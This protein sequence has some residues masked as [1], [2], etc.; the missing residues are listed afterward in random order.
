MEWWI[1]TR[2]IKF[3]ESFF[4]VFVALLVRWMFLR[5]IRVC[6]SFIFIKVLILIIN[7]FYFYS[8]LIWVFIFVFSSTLTY[9]NLCFYHVFFKKVEYVLTF[10]IVTNNL[11]PKLSFSE[12]FIFFLLH[13][14]KIAVS[15][16][17]ILLS[18]KI[19]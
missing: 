5:R 10:E 16:I 9:F 2:I 18:I 13:F 6:N 11:F 17:S 15:T 12:F 19:C 1:W 8:C 3:S 14:A 7:W 4:C